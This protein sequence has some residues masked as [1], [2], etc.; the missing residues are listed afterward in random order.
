MHIPRPRWSEGVVAIAPPEDRAGSWAGGP[1]ALFHDGK[2]W[3]AYRLRRPVD[4]GRGYANVVACSDDGVRFDEVARVTK[5]DFGAAS[6]ERPALTVTPDGTWR[7]YVSCSTSGSKHWW[8][9]V[10][11]AES[12]KELETSVARRRT[13]LPGSA[14][15]AVKDPVVLHDSGSWHLWASVHPLDVVGEEDRMTTNYATSPDGL[16]WTWQGTVL[17]GRPESWDSRGVRVSSVAVDGPN[18]VATYDG[19]ANAA[20]NWEEATGF[21]SG[22]RDDTGRFTALVASIDTPLRSPHDPGGLRYLSALALPDGG[23]RLY[24]EGTRADGAHELRTEL[25]PPPA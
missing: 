7:L 5:G 11:E 17:S 2:F 18:L 15:Y 19:R 12:A 21:A 20:E 23:W 22:T 9:D 10:L 16:D 6:L 1:S 25:V 4:E 3:L 8:V 24:Y 14:E 13:V